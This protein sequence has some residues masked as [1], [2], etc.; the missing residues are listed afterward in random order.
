M[1]VFR[2]LLFVIGC[3]VFALGMAFEVIPCAECRLHCLWAMARHRMLTKAI[4]EECRYDCNM[5]VREYVSRVKSSGKSE[6]AE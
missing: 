2:I 6:T 4:L 1:F 3:A 5:D